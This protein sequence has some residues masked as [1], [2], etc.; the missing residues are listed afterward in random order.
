MSLTRLIRHWLISELNGKRTSI[1]SKQTDRD[2]SAVVSLRDRALLKPWLGSLLLLLYIYYTYNIYITF[3]FDF[4]ANFISHSGLACVV[5]L[6]GTG[7]GLSRATPCGMASPGQSPSVR[8]IFRPWHTRDPSKSRTW[9]SSKGFGILCV[10]FWY[11]SLP[12]RRTVKWMRS[13]WSLDISRQGS[14]TVSFAVWKILIL[15]GS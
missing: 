15:F 6:A 8:G 4:A 5:D 2:S 3:I 1:V 13:T 11:S 9:S 14:P 7:R 10:R 12:S